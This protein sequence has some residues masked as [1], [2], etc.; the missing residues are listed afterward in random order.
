MKRKW[1]FVGI[2]GLVCVLV[3]IGGSLWIVGRAFL[4]EQATY[5]LA[6]AVYKNDTA[7]ALAALRAGADPNTRLRPG[8]PISL[9]QF[10]KEFWQRMRGAKKQTQTEHS[11]P[12]IAVAATKNNTDIVQVLLEKGARPDEFTRYSDDDPYDETDPTDGDTALMWA[13]KNNNADLTETLLER[14][15]HPNFADSFRGEAPLFHASDPAVMESLLAHGANVHVELKHS[16][17]A[18]I[19]PLRYTILGL[20]IEGGR[21]REERQ[22]CYRCVEKLLA[23]GAD[24]NEDNGRNNEDNAYDVTAIQMAAQHGEPADIRFLLSKGANPYLRNWTGE[25]ALGSAIE[26]GVT[27]NIKTLLAYGVDQNRPDKNGRTPLFYAVEH[28]ED[29]P[30]KALI[31]GGA[32][33]NVKDKDGKTPLQLAE[34]DNEDQ[35]GGNNSV[36]DILRAAGARDY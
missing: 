18:G 15:A 13:A 22:K 7:S 11:P 34:S 28:G 31:R 27:E 16:K 32:K 9:L 12:M 30:V 5:N 3:L 14:G 23:H 29:D 24:I 35:P 33:V 19:T 25:D 21:N 8:Q 26:D 17:F 2:V 1:R 10:C 6:V 20:V 4:R 36:E